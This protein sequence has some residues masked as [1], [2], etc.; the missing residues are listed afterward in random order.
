MLS[1]KSSWFLL[2]GGEGDSE[3]RWLIEPFG[4]ELQ[5]EYRPKALVSDQLGM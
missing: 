5:T 2:Q 1:I 3:E 4:L